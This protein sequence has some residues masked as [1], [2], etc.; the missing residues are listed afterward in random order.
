MIAPNITLLWSRLFKFKSI[1]MFIQVLIKSMSSAEELSWY[2]DNYEMPNSGCIK[3][4]LSEKHLVYFT[5]TNKEFYTSAELKCN[6]KFIYIFK[7]IIITHLKFFVT[8]RTTHWLAI[9]SNRCKQTWKYS[10]RGMMTTD[11]LQI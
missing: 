10:S 2:H 11:Y 7:T 8:S 3:Y 9:T 1:I 6:Y 5:A 4:S